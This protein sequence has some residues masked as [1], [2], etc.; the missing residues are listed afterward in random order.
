MTINKNWTGHARIDYSTDMD[1]AANATGNNAVT[2][3]DPGFRVER[4]WVQ[5]DYKNLQIDLGKMGYK[6]MADGGLLVNRTMSGGRVIFGDAVKVSLA[7]GRMNDS[8]DGI[9]F[10]H[11]REQHG[12][13][14]MTA[15]NRIRIVEDDNIP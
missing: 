1:N 8:Y 4:M 2:N 15:W 12:Q 13:I 9:V 14:I 11:G 7:L 6:T 5:G 10:Q 3:G